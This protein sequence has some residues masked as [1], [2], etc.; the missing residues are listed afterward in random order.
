MLAY[1]T[2]KTPRGKQDA[3]AG[4]NGYARV[5]FMSQDSPDA[6][7][8]PSPTQSGGTATDEYVTTDTGADV[9]AEGGWEKIDDNTWK[10]VVN[11]FNDNAVYDVWEETIPGYTSEQYRSA[12]KPALKLDGSESKTVT[13]TNK[14]DAAFGELKVSK[15][16][17]GYTTS[18]KFPIT[19]KLT[20]DNIP[21][22]N[23]VFNVTIGSSTNGVVF[24]NGEGVVRLAHGETAVIKDVEPIEYQQTQQYDTDEPV[25]FDPFN[26]NN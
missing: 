20:G 21:K 22:G 4:Y 18:Q 11:V 15:T 14:A 12:D 6:P 2:Y 26:R 5:T 24:T 10:Y 16:V 25:G 17:S 8:A 9:D 13:V 7:E 23:K 1:E 3:M 19:V